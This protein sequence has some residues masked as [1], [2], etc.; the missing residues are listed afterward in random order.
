MAALT[1]NK[2]PTL[3]QSKATS[4]ALVNLWYPEPDLDKGAHG[5][6]YLIPS[7]SMHNPNALLGV[8]FDSDREAMFNA[9]HRAASAGEAAPGPVHDAPNPGG[10]KLTV[11]MGGHLWGDLPREHWPDEARAIDMAKEAVA[12]QLPGLAAAKVPPLASAKLSWDCIPR[13]DV[14][15]FGRMRAARDEIDRAFGGRLAV[16]GGSYQLPGVLPSL[17]AGRD[18]AAQMAGHFQVAALLAK[19]AKYPLNPI[20]L[21]V[22]R[23]EVFW[24][25]GV[26]GLGRFGTE[27]LANYLLLPPRALPY[28]YLT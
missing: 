13:H 26:T 23:N 17:R 20:P 28:R 6:G 18:M 16:A 7:S 12:A 5:F 11:M 24:S 19:T 2:L 21:D 9:R 14:G 1:N 8:L 25:P 4:V 22:S 27:M 15:H 10:T 3:A